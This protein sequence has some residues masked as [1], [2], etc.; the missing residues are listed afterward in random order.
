MKIEIS[1]KSTLTIECFSNKANHG[2]SFS[3]I[4]FR[5]GKRKP[6]TL[7]H[8]H[9]SKGLAII[10]ALQ[11][12]I[13]TID[14]DRGSFYESPAWQRLRYETLKKYRE[15]CLCGSSRNLHVDHVKPRS[16]H[17]ELAL[18]PENLQVLCQQCNLAKSNR[19][20]EDYRNIE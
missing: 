8:M 13:A 19:D 11:A 12:C 6:K 15:C 18:E 10:D 1:K 4:R 17:P 5:I 3:G 14:N 2:Q 16:K 20:S 7:F 9:H